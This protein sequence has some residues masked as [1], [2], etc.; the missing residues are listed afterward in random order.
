ML[1]EFVNGVRILHPTYPCD[2]VPQDVIL[3]LGR[4]NN[5]DNAFCKAAFLR[6]HVLERVMSQIVL[7]FSTNWRIERS[8]YLFGNMRY[9][10]LCE[11]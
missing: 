4:A 1:N 7:P 5:L 9:D 6:I 8:C 10:Q 3:E 11:E 2:K